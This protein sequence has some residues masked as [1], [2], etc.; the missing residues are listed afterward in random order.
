[1]ILFINNTIIGYSGKCTGRYMHTHTH[2]VT[3]THTHTVKQ[4]PLAQ[5]E[6]RIRNTS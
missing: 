2:T 4:V 6:K 5:T 3:H 1:M